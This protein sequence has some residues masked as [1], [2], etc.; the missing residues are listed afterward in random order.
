MRGSFGPFIIE[1]NSSKLIAHSNMSES[2]KARVEVKE[3]K[4]LKPLLKFLS[5]DLTELKF[6]LAFRV[7]NGVNPLKELEI[8]KK[9]FKNGKPHNFILGDQNYG[10]YLITDLGIKYDFIDNQGI[11]WDIVV[12]VSLKEAIEEKF[13]KKKKI[14]NVKKVKTV[15][16]KKA[17]DINTGSTQ[18][19]T[20]N[21]TTSKAKQNYVGYPNINYNTGEVTR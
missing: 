5:E 6:K 12:D 17:A 11:P 7:G 1:V 16:K 15:E 3:R 8:L 20:S 14:K 10:K 19:T 18:P 9:I 21:S 13:K 2:R 4:N